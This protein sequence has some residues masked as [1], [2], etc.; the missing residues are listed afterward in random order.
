LYDSNI[1]GY[2]NNIICRK[3]PQLVT[4]P[5]SARN[6]L[7]AMFNTLDDREQRTDRLMRNLSNLLG[8]VAT[9]TALAG[10]LYYFDA[11]VLKPK[12]HPY[13]DL[14]PME[15]LPFFQ[16]LVLFMHDH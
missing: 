10:A 6:V 3:G 7:V 16:S 13:F 12:V 1:Y 8:A 5:S 14:A 2:I 15:S 4:I 11:P 9:V